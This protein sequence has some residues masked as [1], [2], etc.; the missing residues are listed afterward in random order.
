[1]TNNSKARPLAAIVGERLKEFREQLNLRQ[2]DLATAAAQAGLA[3][4]RSSIAALE[5]GTR[6]LTVEEVIMLPLVISNAGGLREPLIPPESL[7]LLTQHSHVKAEK[8]HES[9][10]LLTSGPIAKHLSAVVLPDAQVEVPDRSDVDD[11]DEGDLELGVT[12]NRSLADRLSGLEWVR[13]EARSLIFKRVIRQLYPAFDLRRL[14]RVHAGDYDLRFKVGRRLAVPGSLIDAR[15][16]IEPFS[17]A[18]WGHP[19]E[20]E[21]DA[22]AGS[23]GPYPSPRSEQ[24]ARGH[25]TREMIAE[26]NAV[27]HEAEPFLTL[28]MSDAAVVWSDAERLYQWCWDMARAIG[29]A[30]IPEET[31]ASLPEVGRTVK[32]ARTEAAMTVH[33]VGDRTG[34]GDEWIHWVESGR[35]PL[36]MELRTLEGIITEIAEV[37]GLDVGEMREMLHLP[38]RDREAGGKKRKRRGA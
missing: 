21:R 33:A 18:L 38:R 9:L 6:N 7:V 35:V 37:I 19:F 2:S 8:M 24:A 23:K 25:V 3:W 31:V 5:A 11:A 12:G 32:A 17:L 27:I 26:L 16:Y 1:M 29:E 4:S 10:Q 36:Q 28:W 30:R 14:D 15:E 22:R 34:L 13:L 20:T